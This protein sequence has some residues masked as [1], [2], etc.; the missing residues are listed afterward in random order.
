MKKKETIKQTD[1]RLQKKDR[2]FDDIINRYH[3]LS[4]RLIATKYVCVCVYSIRMLVCKQVT[5]F[6]VRNH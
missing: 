6:G 3:R 5:L 4:N 2:R 1:K